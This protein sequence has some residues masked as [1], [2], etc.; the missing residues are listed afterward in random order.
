MLLYSLEGGVDFF[1]FQG[2]VSRAEGHRER[3]AFFTCG[4]AFTLVEIKNTDA[5]AVEAL[6]RFLSEFNE[7]FLDIACVYGLI[8]DECEVLGGSGL[9]TDAAVAS[10]FGFT[11]KEFWSHQDRTGDHG[12]GQ[13]PAVFQSDN[14]KETASDLEAHL[15]KVSRFCGLPALPELAVFNWFE[16]ELAGSGACNV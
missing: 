14:V 12:C 9:I 6:G 11:L 10:A 8:D 5:F 3:E 7:V 15:S 16:A 1:V 2:A 4:E 13:I